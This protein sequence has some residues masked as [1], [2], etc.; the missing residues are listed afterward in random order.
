M[1]D[2]DAKSWVSILSR[3]RGSVLRRTVIPVLLVAALGGVAVWLHR[4]HE[5]HVPPLAHTL[6][7]VALG[8]LLVFR[9]N[10]SYDRFWEGR[11]QL[12]MLVNRARDLC[13]QAASFIEGDDAAA[14][15]DRAEVKRLTVVLYALIRQYL[16]KERSLDAI[17]AL[18]DEERRALEPIAVRPCV[19][20]TWISRR[21][22]ACARA[23]RLTEHRLAAMD[24]NLTSFS[25][26]WGGAERIMKT[27]V[28]FAYAHHIKA[29]LIVFA[30]TAPFALVETMN[31]MTPLASAVLAFALFGIDEIAVEIEDPFGYDE[32]DLPLDAVGETID[33]DAADI[34]RVADPPAPAV[35]ASL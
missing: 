18:T 1:V 30:F 35:A 5:L 26:N 19:A 14:R 29:F 8:L 9:T 24:Q 31:W 34:A 23:G 6:L 7:G 16:R 25:D 10:S 21:L 27:P 15:R 32:N 17:A 22:V 3:V 2:Y 28:P 33:R 12:G 20:F 4:T 13:R 11:K